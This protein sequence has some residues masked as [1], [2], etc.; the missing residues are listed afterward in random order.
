MSTE[1]TA[2]TPLP[3]RLVRLWVSTIVVFCMPITLGFD[4]HHVV[5]RGADFWP[6][7]YGRGFELG[8]GLR[9]GHFMPAKLG[10]AGEPVVR[11]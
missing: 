11:P 5:S 6:H 10:L 3:N 9:K 1:S 4:R 2:R 7:P 8:A